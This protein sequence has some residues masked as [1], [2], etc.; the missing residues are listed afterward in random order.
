MEILNVISAYFSPTG[1]TRKVLEAVSAGTGAEPAGY[2]DLTLP[3]NI[4]DQITGHENDLIIFGA[5]V[6]GGRL[7]T[8]AVKRFSK[9]KGSNTPA[10]IVVVYGNR[11]FEDALLELGDLVSGLGFIPVAGAAFIGEHSFSSPEVPIAEGRPDSIDLN[12]AEKFGT[13]VMDKISS[14]NKITEISNVPFP[15]NRPYKDPIPPNDQCTMTKKD[16]CTNCNICV[17]LCPANA[18]ALDDDLTTDPDLCI[19]CCACVKGCPED[20]RVI[21][22]EHIRM[23]KNWLSETCG[24]PK[25]PEIFI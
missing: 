15:G 25:Q 12:I 4:K 17:D 16:K 5:P 18:I 24:T 7:P 8:D 19:L 10:V 9:L 22:S 2:I 13:A 23:V 21:E 6:Y 20:A 1:T 11:E 14:V 3:V